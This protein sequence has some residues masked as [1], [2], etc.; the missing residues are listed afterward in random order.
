[1][2]HL[3]LFHAVFLTHLDRHY[4]DLVLVGVDVCADGNLMPFMTFQCVRVADSPIKVAASANRKNK[5]QNLRIPL[6]TE[7]GV[8]RAPDPRSVVKWADRQDIIL[9]EWRRLPSG[10]GR[11]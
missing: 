7:K 4:I 1:V 10:S 3:V 8:P 9:P 2:L 5:F 11:W 6:C